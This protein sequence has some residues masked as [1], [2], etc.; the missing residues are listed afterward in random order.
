MSTF[1]WIALMCCVTIIICKVINTISYHKALNTER[2]LYSGVIRT[3]KSGKKLK[4]SPYSLRRTQA[5]NGNWGYSVCKS[6]SLV[7]GSDYRYQ[8][9]SLEDAT[10]LMNE[11]ERVD[12][13]EQTIF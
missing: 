1:I 5:R 9:L 6:G 12:G 2:D 11:M 8:V 13:C 4:K 10:E 7:V 3:T